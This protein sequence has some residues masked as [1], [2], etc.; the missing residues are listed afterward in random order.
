MESSGLTV[1]TA[2]ITQADSDFSSEVVFS[3]PSFNE[4]D[5]NNSKKY[6]EN[7]LK[8]TMGFVSL[9]NDFEIEYHLFKT[10]S[11][12]SS[13]TD[14]DKKKSSM[15]IEISY[16][17]IVQQIIAYNTNYSSLEALEA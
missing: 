14:V 7:I 11:N 8:S 4:S 16:L 5:V 9:N 15:S 13:I 10:P 1:N 17:D 12:G 6:L 2:S 3:I